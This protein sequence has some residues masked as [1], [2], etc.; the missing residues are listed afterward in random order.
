MK[1]FDEAARIGPSDRG[2]AVLGV[3]D[4]KEELLR[5][6]VGPTQR[7]ISKIKFQIERGEGGL[8]AKGAGGASGEKR[9]DGWDGWGEAENQVRTGTD[10]HGPTWTVREEEGSNASAARDASE[11]RRISKIRFEI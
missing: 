7:E 8:D 3:L 5:V 1:S 6:S 4:L 10:K 9:S 2:I 11:E